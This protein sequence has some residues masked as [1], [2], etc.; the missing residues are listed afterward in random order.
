MNLRAYIRCS[1]DMSVGIP[2]SEGFVDLGVNEYAGWLE[3][4]MREWVKGKLIEIFN[5]LHDNGT[6]SVQFS[7]EC[8]ECGQILCKSGYC[9]S[10]FLH[11]L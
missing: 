10:C 2:S 11:E 4:G 8:S 5:E 6:P 3:D 9:K 7:D 1:G